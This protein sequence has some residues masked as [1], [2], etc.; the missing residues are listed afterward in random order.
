MCCRSGS[1]TGE[2]QR[3]DETGLRRAWR[4]VRVRASAGVCSFS[5]VPK[6][7]ERR[8]VVLSSHYPPRH[9]DHLSSSSSSSSLSSP[10]Y[11]PALRSPRRTTPPATREQAGGRSSARRPTSRRH[12]D[13][14][15]TASDCEYPPCII[16]RAARAGP[17]SG[18]EDRTGSIHSSAFTPCSPPVDD[19]IY[20]LANTAHS[21]AAAAAAATQ[22]PDGLLRRA[23]IRSL[24][25]QSTHQ[26]GPGRTQRIPTTP[27]RR[28]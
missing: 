7:A 16:L 27:S 26:P 3:Q 23:C 15:T 13:D 18:Q 4:A 11:S 6:K 24:A 21:A 5:H 8:P 12:D 17:L 22:P 19:L 10:T 9:C 2:K 14:T 1:E 25:Q 20:T 28:G